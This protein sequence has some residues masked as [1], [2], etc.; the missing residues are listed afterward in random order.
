MRIRATGDPML[1]HLIDGLHR[2]ALAEAATVAAL[3]ML[4]QVSF[5]TDALLRIQ[6]EAYDALEADNAVS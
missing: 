2:K 3:L 6:Q 5:G 4:I 1:A